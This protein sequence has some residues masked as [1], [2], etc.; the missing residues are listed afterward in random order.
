MRQLAR[1]LTVLGLLTS[2][3]LAL[4]DD[5]VA[6]EYPVAL[7]DRPLALNP[8]TFQ[9]TGSFDIRHV[10]VGDVSANATALNISGDYSP[11]RHVQLG[12][13]VGIQLSPDADFGYAIATGQYE[14]FK[15]AAIRVDIGVSNASDVQAFVGAGLPIRL[16]LTNLV[17]FVSSRPYAWNFEDDIVSA[18]LGNGSNTEFN[19][20][21]G[22]LFQFT[23]RVSATLHS[24]FRER[25][26]ASFVPF[27]I[28]L[29]LETGHID[30]G[31]MFDVDGQ[32]RPDDGPGYFD[33]FRFRLFAMIRV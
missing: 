3:H 23:P 18:R 33:A 30:L 1:V 20:P 12:A 11:L 6:P 13:S 22:L 10:S 26:S 16:K 5:E 29:M 24:G 14:F 7:I 19:L 32:F 15:F 31:A 2:A 21:L 9:L 25:D 4:A 28:D 8:S 17:A 27:G